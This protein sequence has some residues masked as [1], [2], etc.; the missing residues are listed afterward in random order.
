MTTLSTRGKSAAVGAAEGMA[1]GA[2]AGGVLG[3]IVGMLAGDWLRGA[4]VGSGIGVVVGGGV[5]YYETTP[6]PAGA[7]NVVPMAGTASAYTVKA[8]TTI[9]V[10][11]PSGVTWRT[12][13]ASSDNALLRPNSDGT[14]TAVSAGVA[15]INVTGSDSAGTFYTAA[16]TI[17]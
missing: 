14:F 8:G 16:I 10:S 2:F 11:A 7:V 1:A 6:P 13:P 3:L 12:A 9:S 4:A 15:D 17:Q 5:G